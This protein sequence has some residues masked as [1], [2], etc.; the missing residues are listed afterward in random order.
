MIDVKKDN[1]NLR[2]DVRMIFEAQRGSGYVGD[3][4]IDD[5]EITEGPCIREQGMFHVI[6]LT[7]TYCYLVELVFA[8]GP[9][10]YVQTN[11]N[12]LIW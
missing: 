9:M 1:W 10:F 8:D 7:Y 4:A 6:L 5:V 3:I 2:G 12:A 11:T